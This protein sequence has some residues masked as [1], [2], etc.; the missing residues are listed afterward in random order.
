MICKAT[1]VAPAGW[2]DSC[3]PTV[4]PVARVKLGMLLPSVPFGDFFA[5][6]WSYAKTL[7]AGC[8][9]ASG[10]SDWV[11]AGVWVSVWVCGCA[12]SVAAT[13]NV[14]VKTRLAQSLILPSSQL[15]L[16][17]PYTETSSTHR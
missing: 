7:E 11:W 3:I 8:A 17:N 9:P 14:A 4:S 15:R 2:T 12:Q 13:N 10:F 1:G 16:Q 6:I 5:G